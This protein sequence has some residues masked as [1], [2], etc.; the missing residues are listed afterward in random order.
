MTS[1]F[2]RKSIRSLANARSCMILRRPELVAAV[3]DG[4]LGGEPGEEQRFLEGRVPSADNGDLLVP[5]E[6]AVAGGTRRDPVGEQAASR[7]ADRA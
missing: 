6:E 3:D 2:Q 7:S 1:A 4:D 5:E